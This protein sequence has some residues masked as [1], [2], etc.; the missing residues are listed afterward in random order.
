MDLKNEYVF[1]MKHGIG[2]VLID[3]GFQLKI[4]YLD[5]IIEEDITNIQLLDKLIIDYI[6]NLKFEDFYNYQTIIKGKEYIKNVES[7]YFILEDIKAK[8]Y[9][10]FEYICKISFN[11]SKFQT[12]C[13]CPVN[14]FCK[15][16]YA[17]FYKIYNDIKLLDED[18]LD[19]IEYN[20]KRIID[21]GMNLDKYEIY[22]YILENRFLKSDTNSLI[23]I[24]K[25]DENILTKLIISLDD[26]I[27]FNIPKNDILYDYFS[28]FRSSVIN[29]SDITY[30]YLYLLLNNKMDYNNINIYHYKL[31]PFLNYIFKN[32]KDML[33][34]VYNDLMNDKDI[35][36]NVI[37]KLANNLD[38]N[39]KLELIDKK[40]YFEL[41]IED[42]LNIDNDKKMKYLMY[43][44]YEKKYKYFIENIKEI[45]K[46][47]KLYV[48]LI[49]RLYVE[50]DYYQKK[51]I[52]FYID[53]L[54]N[55]NIKSLIL[56][57]LIFPYN[58]N[59]D[60]DE[61]FFDILDI[62]YDIDEYDNNYYIKYDIYIF[63]VLLFSFSNNN[64]TYK[65]KHRSNSQ[66]FENKFISY[67]IKYLSKNDQYNLFLNNYEIRIKELKNQ[68]I[69]SE[70]NNIIDK[71]NESLLF[72][73]LNAKIYPIL[74]ISKEYKYLSLKISL[75]NT[76]KYIVSNI[77]NL[78]DSINLKQNYKYGKELEFNHD[79]NNFD[80]TSKELIDLL[81]IIDTYDYNRVTN[82]KN[83]LINDYI[84]DKLINIYKNNYIEINK[85]D[86][87]IKLDEIIFNVTI[88]ENY[89]LNNDFNYKYI[90]SNNNIYLIDEDN[91]LINKI[92]DDGNINF[93]KF[94]LENK[95][96]DISIIKDKF[97]SD[98]YD[99]Y[100]EIIKI[101]DKIKN[102]FK[103]S[104][105][106]IEAYFDY[107]NYNILIDVKIIKDSN[108]ISIDDLS[109]V[110]K[111]KYEKFEKYIYSLGFKDN[112]IEDI[113]LVYNF[114]TMDFSYLKELANIYL[115]ESIKNKKVTTFSGS[116]R[117]VYEN[118]MAYAFYDELNYSKEELYKILDNIK[119]RKKF[120]IL[121]DDKIIDLDNNSYEIY[122]TIV[123]L[124]LDLKN[125]LNKKEIPMYQVLKYNYYKNN[126][127]LDHYLSNMVND[128]NNFKEL[129]FN[130]SDDIKANLRDYQIEGFKF[131]SVLDKYNLSG[132][133]ADDMGLGKT[134]EVISLFASKNINMPII[135]VSPKS[136]IFN[137]EN[138]FLKFYPLAKVKT[139]VGAP[140]IRHDIISNI[141]NNKKIIYLTSYDSLR[142]DIDYYNNTYFRY[143]I[144]DEAQYIKNVG[145]KKTLNVK[146]L[147]GDVKVALS[148]TPIEN[149]VIDLWSIFDFLMPGYLENLTSFKRKYQND[150][151][152]FTKIIAKKCAPF[153]LRR[154]KEDVL[155]DLP[156]KYEKIVSCEMDINQKMIYDAYRLKAQDEIKDDTKKFDILPMLTRLREICISP[157][158]F[159]LDYNHKSAKIDLVIDIIND[160]I[161]D[162]HKILIFSSFV[163]A[164]NLLEVK[165]YNLN[166]KYLLLTGK[167]SSKERISMVDEFNNDFDI[168]VFLISL[169]A[170]GTGL[171]LVGADTV[172]HL[173]PWWNVS[174]EMQATDR[175]YRIGQTKNVEVIKVVC[176]N[177][178]EQRVIELQNVKKDVFDIIINDSS[179]YKNL[180]LDDLNYILK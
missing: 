168:K 133:L 85:I 27:Y 61:S 77:S 157:S 54:E 36:C 96:M 73:K 42:I 119:N 67:I 144:L 143:I 9:G 115:S 8:V 89:I 37:E 41:E 137:W 83:I 154:I 94:S 50:G 19:F 15:H 161:K 107:E 4:K 105:L 171:N 129:D 121:K 159:M 120:V 80:D 76:R 101:D 147:K 127:E 79:I 74:S 110:D 7:Y 177:S 95:G 164:L 13:T 33:N 155:L 152:N 84:F 31:I 57:N 99:R 128:L 35:S 158:L 82:T 64:G 109:I 145:A 102:N 48:F 160:Y 111:L 14:T 130:I 75:D 60:Y 59:L 113:D 29:K 93:Y 52:V 63:E 32:N 131:L 140:D 86:Y 40:P 117:I 118:N 179:L 166:I 135:V 148:G 90:I 44:S 169:K 70:Y 51:K 123:D 150:S 165:L 49:S 65:A 16:S 25:M 151:N 141:D 153:I 162:G 97:S 174:A 30:Y 47:Y 22:D 68:K 98:I 180:S 170:G 26:N 167:N 116:V 78:I 3:Y 176:E 1:N 122:D 92:K 45:K 173:D 72:D 24:H 112:K 58:Y 46:D 125:L 53:S 138:E 139:I 55:N 38:T 20:I 5:I 108:L 134:L 88:D 100:H 34:K 18:E 10:N 21:E 2:K 104:N 142:L 103:L 62:K 149:N 146:M 66:E 114:L 136:L 156:K 69:I 87:F 43:V 17:V 163:K 11:K 175:T 91:K 71:F 56:H 6:K 172:V 81:N 39:K 132:I 106:I 23:K 12:E 126:L 124:N 178:I 28:N